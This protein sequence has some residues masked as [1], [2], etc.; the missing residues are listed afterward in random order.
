MKSFKQ[1]SEE[2]EATIKGNEEKVVPRVVWISAKWEEDNNMDPQN[3]AWKSTMQKLMLDD[4]ML[5][6][7]VV[8]GTRDRLEQVEEA[9]KK[10]IKE[11]EPIYVDR[12]RR[13]EFRPL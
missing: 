6:E 11:P 8:A 2:Y 7:Q 4:P 3:P 12:V 1:Y 10:G 13:Y 5:F 9:A